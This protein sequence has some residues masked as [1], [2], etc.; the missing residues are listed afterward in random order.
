M[1]AAGSDKMLASVGEQLPFGRMVHRL[2]TFDFFRDCSGM[3]GQIRNE[4]RFFLAGT[5]HEDF[6]GV[7]QCRCDVGKKQLV[8]D[9]LAV[10]MG[11]MGMRMSGMGLQRFGLGRIEVEM[12]DLGLGM[13]EPDDCV[14]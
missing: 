4:G 3:A 12:N 9:W 14:M 5:D 11:Q 13:I 7:F 2:D 8:V 1:Q 6:R 10:A